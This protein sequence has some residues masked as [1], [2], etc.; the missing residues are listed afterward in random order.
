MRRF[1]KLEKRSP[2]MATPPTTAPTFHSHPAR[3]APTAVTRTEYR[4]PRMVFEEPNSG[5]PSTNLTPPSIGYDKR[6]PK[7]LLMTT[8]VPLASV[9]RTSSRRISE[10]CIFVCH[11]PDGDPRSLATTL[12]THPTRT[13]TKDRQIQCN[14]D[15]HHH[16]P[17]YNQNHPPDPPHAPRNIPLHILLNKPAT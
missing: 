6:L 9:N 3:D 12:L 4:T 15:R 8:G 7:T 10:R 16:H 13:Q 1:R 2:A 17:H 14:Q 5:L 11:Q